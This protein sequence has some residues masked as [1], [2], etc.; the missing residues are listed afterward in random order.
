MKRTL[1]K[2]DKKDFQKTIGGKKV[3]S[4]GGAFYCYK[5]G[6]RM[7]PEVQTEGRER[8]Q[9]AEFYLDT[10]CFCDQK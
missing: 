9:R 7:I 4:L 5:C 10:T 2:L 1:V 3:V 8:F 6:Y